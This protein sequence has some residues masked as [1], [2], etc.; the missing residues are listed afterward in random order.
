VA[1]PATTVEQMVRVAIGESVAAINAQKERRRADLGQWLARLD[2]VA[3]AATVAVVAARRAQIPAVRSLTE[4]LADSALQIFEL[5]PLADGTPMQAVL[6]NMVYKT[7]LRG[8]TVYVPW[9]KAGERAYAMSPAAIERQLLGVAIPMNPA[10]RGRRRR[11]EQRQLGTLAPRPTT[12]PPMT[13]VPRHATITP[14][15]YRISYRMPG[16]CNNDIN[17]TQLRFQETA[18]MSTEVGYLTARTTAFLL[19]QHCGVPELHIVRRMCHNRVY[20]TYL[21]AGVDLPLLERRGLTAQCRTR[22]TD[23]NNIVMSSTLRFRRLRMLV[24]PS[25]VVICVGAK[26]TTIMQEAM[27]FFLPIIDAAR[28]APT[29]LP[30]G[31]GVKRA[32]DAALSRP[33]KRARHH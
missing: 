30:Q 22:I 1:P 11:R 29:A 17:P 7:A 19:A 13:I 31:Q 18:A 33:D 2:P 5:A 20:V 9:A 28:L 6:V 8:S 16:S 23:F 27:A 26:T 14:C 12:A 4:V 21:R 24:F 32:A 25:G 10:N 15:Q 3:D